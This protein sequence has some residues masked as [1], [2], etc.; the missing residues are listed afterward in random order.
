MRQELLGAFYESKQREIKSFVDKCAY[1]QAS[2]RDV[3]RHSNLREDEV[4][5]IVEA[6]FSSLSYELGGDYIRHNK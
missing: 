6:G 5:D 2:V 4:R 3:C 1:R